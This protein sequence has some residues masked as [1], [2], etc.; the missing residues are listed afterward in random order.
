MAL[1]K[2]FPE[3]I[4]TV[5]EEISEALIAAAT[6]GEIDILV[7]A[8][9]FDETCLNVEPLFSDTF[10]LPLTGTAL[11]PEWNLFLLIPWGICL[12]SCWKIFI[13]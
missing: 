10:I 1:S 6:C 4:V 3:A 8:L 5:R 11:W 13:V 12:L 7:E 9:P 2:N